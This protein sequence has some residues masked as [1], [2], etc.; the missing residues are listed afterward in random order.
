MVN[1]R[2]RGRTVRVA[3]GVEV[4]YPEPTSEVATKIG[5]ANRRVGTK[6]EIALRSELHRRGLRFRKDLLVR[7]PSAKARVDVVFP[8]R[9][10]A[11]FVDGCF[12][13]VCPVHSSTPKSNLDYWGPKLRANVERDR[14]L[15]EA[16]SADGWVVVRVWEHEDIASAATTIEELVRRRDR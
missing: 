7:V 4:P 3:A 16:F 6:P 5:R 11:I 8:K 15:D 10:I 13:H 14:R 2:T 9:R 1:H 12:W